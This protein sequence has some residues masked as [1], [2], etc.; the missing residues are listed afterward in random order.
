MPPVNS[1]VQEL[2]LQ[3]PRCH[4]TVQLFEGARWVCTACDAEYP[5]VEGIPDFRVREGPFISNAHDREKAIRIASETA[6]KT[7][8]ELVSHYYA[9]TPEVPPVDALRFSETIMRGET[10]AK[11]LLDDWEI[12]HDPGTR[13]LDVGCGTGPL[14]AA[15]ASRGEH[16][17]AGVDIALR[18][19]VIARQRLQEAGV[20]CPLVCANA[21]ALPWGNATFTH[22]T[23]ASSLEHMPKQT[24]V[25]EEAA[26]VMGHGGE[27][28]I[29]TPNR[30]SLGPDP[31]IRVWGGGYLPDWAVAALSKFRK[32]LPPVRRLLS[33]RGLAQMMERSGFEE[34]SINPAPIPD[35]EMEGTTLRALARRGYRLGSRAPILRWILKQWGPILSV[36]GRRR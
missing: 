22:L 16:I 26:R 2:P 31:H 19:L 34:I 23:F 6:G 21:E 4:M 25:L 13:L 29:Y 28:Y 30:N 24:D 10:L 7:F 12:P 1:L 5:V 35:V 17:A 11:C 15:A 18:W 33:A 14:L 27:V 9:I 20:Q 3:C 36:N 32:A 8:R